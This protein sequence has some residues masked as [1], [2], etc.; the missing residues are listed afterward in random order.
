VSLKVYVNGHFVPKD[1][2]VISVYDHGFLY[3]DGVFEGVRVYNGRAFRLD[4]HL[5]RLYES[6]KTVA[7]DMPFPPE[8][9]K[10]KVL[11]TI[12]INGLQDAYV[13]LVVSRG[14]GDLGIDPRKC[15]EPTIVIIAE[16]ITLY[17]EELYEKGLKVVTVPTRRM[18]SE[19]VNPRV[20]SLNYLN[21]ILAKVEGNHLGYP[22]VIMLNSEGYV[23]EGSAD[24]IFIVRDGAVITPAPHLGILEGITRNAV[25]EL[26]RSLELDMREEVFTRH[27]LF[28]A[29]E[30]FLTGTAAELIPVVEVDGRKIGD[31]K[32]G[33]V[34][35]RLWEAF[36]ELR[37][38][39]GT[40]VYEGDKGR[41]SAD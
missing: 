27:D 28:N 3:G 17:P 30:C 5:K 1:Q 40:P 12:R 26:A 22:E 2:A 9:M 8:E 38:T 19:M 39:T 13:R 37:E 18:H 10:E 34:T 16:S 35:R 11:Q 24:N 7:L 29:D 23:V 21:N 36:K 6:A 25:M 31:G 14:R 15:P 32:P 33:P 41:A 20:K 4:E